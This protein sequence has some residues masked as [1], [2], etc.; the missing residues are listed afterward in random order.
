M[1]IFT[2]H[3]D[4]WIAFVGMFF[5]AIGIYVGIRVDLKL[6][7][8]RIKNAKEDQKDLEAKVERHVENSA[9]HFHQ[10]VNDSGLWPKVGG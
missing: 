5:A 6:M 7:H 2:N 3:A 8:E 10:R 9:I 4:A 1:E